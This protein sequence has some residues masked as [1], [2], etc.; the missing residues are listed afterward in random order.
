VSNW[1]LCRGVS[2]HKDQLLQDPLTFKQSSSYQMFCFFHYIFSFFFTALVV[3]SHNDHPVTTIL[4]HYSPMAWH[5]CAENAAKHQPTN[6][7]DPCRNL[8][9][10][11]MGSASRIPRVNKL[12]VVG[13]EFIV[14][15]LGSWKLKCRQCYWYYCYLPFLLSK[16][17]WLPLFLWR[18]HLVWYTDI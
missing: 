12:N 2:L 6:E 7:P 3:H 5:F 15:K 10:I 14:H 1:F 11:I 4:T 9:L 18:Y 17:L 13:Y 16:F 8:D